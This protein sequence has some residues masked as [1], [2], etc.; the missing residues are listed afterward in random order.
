MH[1]LHIYNLV[2]K[3]LEIQSQSKGT[4]PLKLTKTIQKL[5]KWK[6]FTKLCVNIWLPPCPHLNLTMP[7][8][9]V[10]ETQPTTKAHKIQKKTKYTKTLN[11]RTNTHFNTQIQNITSPNRQVHM[12]IY[13]H[14]HEQW[15]YTNPT[16]PPI[17][18]TIIHK[19]HIK[20]II[21]IN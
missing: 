8:F 2:T 14:Y 21:V 9:K 12:Y 19:R 20:V 5:K 4:K 6:A 15:I 3:P 13:N 10:E 1:I 16:R 7:S 11:K 18:S 17:Q